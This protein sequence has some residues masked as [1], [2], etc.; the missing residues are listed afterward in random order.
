M[1]SVMLLILIRLCHQEDTV[2]KHIGIGAYWMGSVCA[3][4]GLFARAL[5]M[6][7]KN[8]F[9][10]GTRGG[11]IGYHS[12]MDGTL[13]FYSISI[14]T[15]VYTGFKSQKSKSSTGDKSEKARQDTLS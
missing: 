5:D 3:A 10:F 13:F 11:G 9:D 12:L 1:E 4:S 7:G 6:F 8:F 14:A 2:G 15:I